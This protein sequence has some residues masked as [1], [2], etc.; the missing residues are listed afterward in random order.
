MRPFK[1]SDL[2]RVVSINETIPRP[3]QT[4][5]GNREFNSD[6]DD[7]IGYDRL[8]NINTGCVYECLVGRITEMRKTTSQSLILFQLVYPTTSLDITLY[9]ISWCSNLYQWGNDWIVHESTTVKLCSRKYD[10]DGFCFWKIFQD[11]IQTFGHEMLSW[12]RLRGINAHSVS[13]PAR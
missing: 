12:V 9:Q 1:L 3:W 13:P 6:S 5:R 8:W 4:F 10:S 7:R 11:Y 2:M